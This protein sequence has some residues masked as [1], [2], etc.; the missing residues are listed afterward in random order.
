MKRHVI[1]FTESIS[2]MRRIL[3]EL[4]E[5][6]K[7][8]TDEVRKVIIS[9]I[10]SHINAKFYNKNKSGKM[11]VTLYDEQALVFNELNNHA[12]FLTLQLL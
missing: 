1:K 4:D 9:R 11:T 7:L 6:E 2:T 3:I 10:A 5:Y 8:T 12:A